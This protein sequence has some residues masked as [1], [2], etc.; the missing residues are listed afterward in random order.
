MSETIHLTFCGARPQSAAQHDLEDEPCGSETNRRSGSWRCWGGASAAAGAATALPNLFPF[1][2]PSALLET[3]S[4][5]GSLDESGPFFQSLGTNGRTCATCH[6]PQDGFGLS[7][8]HAERVYE[9]TGGRDPLFAPVHG[10]VCPTATP[11]HPLSFDLLRHYGLIRIALP[12]PANPQFTITVVHDPYGCALVVD[13]GTG[14][15]T[16]SVYRRPLPATNLDF[17]TA[18]MFDG[19]ETVAPLND[20]QTYAA[21]LITDLEHQALDATLGH[22]QAAVPPTATAPAAVLRSSVTRRSSPESTIP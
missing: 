11:G 7:A 5:A 6:V 10:A 18:V 21:N 17:L 9:R 20:P 13:P 2:D 3:F 16:I 22:A 4:S 15:Q 19:R 14:A 12:V 8:E 1:R